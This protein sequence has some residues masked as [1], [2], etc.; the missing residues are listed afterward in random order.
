MVY[1]SINTIVVK[2]LFWNRETE[3]QRDKATDRKTDEET[4]KD[5]NE[6]T[7]TDTERQSKRETE[8]L[9]IDGKRERDGDR[10]TE[11][12]LSSSLLCL[13]SIY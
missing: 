4:D 3:K 11:R 12:H 1:I 7:D 8:R 9:K 13:I 10:E 2:I 5:R 6:Q